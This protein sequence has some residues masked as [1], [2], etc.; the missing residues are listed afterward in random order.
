MIDAGGLLCV[1]REAL[2]RVLQE[3]IVDAA[4]RERMIDAALGVIRREQGA[5]TR[6]EMLLRELLQ[7]TIHA[8]AP[9]Q[10]R[11]QAGRA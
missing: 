1:T 4:A 3:L 11:S 5:T 10:P 9:V 8:H 6:N 2:P 7:E